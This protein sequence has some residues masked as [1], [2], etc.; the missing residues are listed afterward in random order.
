MGL[1]RYG[2]DMLTEL[3]T[4]NGEQS[5]DRV[6]LLVT[7]YAPPSN[8]PCPD[9]LTCYD[10]YDSNQ[11]AGSEPFYITD[12]D[13]DGKKEIF[14][15]ECGGIWVRIYESNGHHLLRPVA[16]LTNLPGVGFALGDFDQD[17]R[18]EFASSGQSWRGLISIDKC[19][20]NDNYVR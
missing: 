15:A 14:F 7:L 10:R 12:L 18:M 17:D 9:H 8:S 19:L 16:T 3:I 5:T 11:V 2:R 20:G 1:G 13:Q 4:L 6:Y